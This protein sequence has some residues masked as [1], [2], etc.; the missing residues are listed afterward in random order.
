MQYNLGQGSNQ[1]SS[2]HLRMGVNPNQLLKYKESASSKK[3]QRGRTRDLQKKL[4]S[5]VPNFDEVELKIGMFKA[6]RTWLQLL[7]DAKRHVLA[8]STTPEGSDQAASSSSTTIPKTI[9]LPETVLTQNDIYNGLLS[10][11]SHFL[12]VVSDLEDGKLRTKSASEPV[13]QVT[14]VKNCDLAIENQYF[15]HFLNSTDVTVFLNGI[16]TLKDSDHVEICCR[17][18]VASGIGLRSAKKRLRIYL[19]R[20][21]NQVFVHVEDFLAQPEWPV[22]MWNGDHLREVSGVLMFDPI[23]SSCSLQTSFQMMQKTFGAVSAVLTASISKMMETSEAKMA[24]ESVL[25]RFKCVKEFLLQRMLQIHVSHEAD[26]DNIVYSVVHVKL[27]LPK[28]LDVFETE[29]HEA[30]RI[31]LD[32]TPYPHPCCPGLYA[33][34]LVHYDAPPTEL[35]ITERYLQFDE[36]K[37]SFTIVHNQTA[38]FTKDQCHY[39]GLLLNDRNELQM[40]HQIWQRVGDYE[41]Q[42]MD[43]TRSCS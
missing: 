36:E 15:H 10:S 4:D 20:A 6:G 5:L 31:K 42:L 41:E 37:K 19:D 43:L 29:W 28:Y 16:A 35:H 25:T 18:L 1:S 38:I 22:K 40:T 30:F 12:L 23:S 8:L 33:S 27:K 34:Y 9:K 39:A 14:Q 3:A 2:H 24:L 17:M 21:A 26:Q 11:K 32:G 7:Q 13:H